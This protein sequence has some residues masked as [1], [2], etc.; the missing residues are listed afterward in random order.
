ME[1]RQEK[2]ITIY[3]NQCYNQFVLDLSVYV[4]IIWFN[5]KT[6]KRYLQNLNKHLFKYYDIFYLQKINIC[7]IKKNYT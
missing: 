7:L 6:L 4:C 1:L 3:Y 2:S 5:A